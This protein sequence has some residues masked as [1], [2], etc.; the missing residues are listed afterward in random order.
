MTILKGKLR[1]SGPQSLKG[2]LEVVNRLLAYPRQTVGQLR[3]RFWHGN[4]DLINENKSAYWKQAYLKWLESQIRDSCDVLSLFS[5]SLTLFRC[6]GF[7]RIWCDVVGRN[8][9]LFGDFA[10][11]YLDKS[12]LTTHHTP[13]FPGADTIIFTVILLFS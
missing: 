5:L 10:K 4:H 13:R 1:R 9:R 2:F 12:N 7:H 11:K 3:R 6:I 8:L